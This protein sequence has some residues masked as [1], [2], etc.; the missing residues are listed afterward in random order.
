[1]SSLHHRAPGRAG[2]SPAVAAC[3][4]RLTALAVVSLLVSGG[5]AIADY[6]RD[7]RAYNLAHGRIVFEQHC[8]QCHASGQRDAPVFGQV[9]DWS[10]RLEQPL[11]RLIT[12]AID[13]H[14]RMPPKGDLA[15]SDQQVAAAVAF[16]VER[17]R[18]LVPGLEDLGKLAPTTAG[19]ERGAS[20]PDDTTMASGNAAVIQMFMLLYGKERWR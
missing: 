18:S 10:Q 14:G 8:M 6:T 1:M 16:V 11:E 17:T 20:V 7:T 2:R 3:R 4:Q 19:G 5:V 9:A 13:G 15:L 12:H